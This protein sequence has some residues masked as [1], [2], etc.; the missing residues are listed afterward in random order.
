MWLTATISTALRAAALNAKIAI[1]SLTNLVS[2]A[3]NI[4]SRVMDLLIVLNVLRVDMAHSVKT[5][6]RARVLTASAPRSAPPAY[7]VTMDYPANTTV[8]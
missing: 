7:A 4:A 2:T 1:I 8:L 3:L 6:A 5:R